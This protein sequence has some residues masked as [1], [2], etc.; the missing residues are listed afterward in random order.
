MKFK[1]NDTVIYNGLI[2]KV[3]D[4]IIEKRQITIWVE[5]DSKEIGLFNHKGFLYNSDEVLNGNKYQLKHL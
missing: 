3:I 5:F 4:V 2:G 1:K